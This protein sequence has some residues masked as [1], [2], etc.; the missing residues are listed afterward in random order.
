M[1]SKRKVSTSQKKLLGNK[2]AELKRPAAPVF[3]CDLGLPETNRFSHLKK[4]KRANPKRKRYSIPTSSFSGGENVSFR[5]GKSNPVAPP[6]G[7]LC[8]SRKFRSFFASGTGPDGSRVT[9]LVW[10][11][12]GGWLKIN[13]GLPKLVN[14][15]GIG[16][17]HPN[18]ETHPYIYIYHI[19]TCMHPRLSTSKLH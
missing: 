14:V 19:S 6:S 7:C 5:E 11:N 10:R 12:V 4:K 2:R 9:R 8:F 13:K 15:Y 17:S 1:A 3:W 16:G 18:F